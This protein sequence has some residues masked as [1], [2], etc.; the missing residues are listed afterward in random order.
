M[1]KEKEKKMKEEIYKR[2][3]DFVDMLLSDE[4]YDRNIVEKALDSYFSF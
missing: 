2:I 1:K 3:N 4:K